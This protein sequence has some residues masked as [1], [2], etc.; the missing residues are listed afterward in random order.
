MTKGRS[1]EEQGIHKT[2][3]EPVYPA[4]ILADPAI[5][6]CP[7]LARGAWLQ[8]LMI[9]WRDGTDRIRGDVP[10]FGRLWGMTEEEVGQVIAAFRLHKP[11]EILRCHGN[12]HNGHGPV[13]LVCRCLRRQLKARAAATKRKR[14]EREREASRDGHA[15]VTAEK[16]PPSSSSSSSPSGTKVPMGG[17]PPV[18]DGGKSRA[19]RPAPF[20]SE[21]EV[22]RKAILD[23]A[24]ELYARYS[25]RDTQPRASHPKEWERYLNL[26]GRAKE[27]RS[28]IADGG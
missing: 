8:T 13:T 12:G 4:D 14:A 6:A 22:Q 17:E 26:K 20:I 11:C 25:F 7:G 2:P 24:N 19:R 21:L 5:Q 3:S 10:T 27:L 28:R 1:H 23:E 16:C 15:P 18:T 9:L